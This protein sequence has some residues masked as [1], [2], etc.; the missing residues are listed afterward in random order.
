MTDLIKRYN[1]MIDHC[2][3]RADY[4]HQ[5]ARAYMFLDTELAY[6]NARIAQDYEE[7]EEMYKKRLDEV[8]KD[9]DDELGGKENDVMYER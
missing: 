8:I 2:R 1:E 9:R 5:D 6:A 7:L 4:Y 3:E